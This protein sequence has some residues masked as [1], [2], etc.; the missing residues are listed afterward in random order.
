M[1]LWIYKPKRAKVGGER[2]GASISTSM[3]ILSWGRFCIHSTVEIPYAFCS[4]IGGHVLCFEVFT[5]LWTPITCGFRK[6]RI[7]F[8]MQSRKPLNQAGEYLAI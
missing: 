6:F 7:Q 5:T 1:D 8:R 4:I 2:L 3:T